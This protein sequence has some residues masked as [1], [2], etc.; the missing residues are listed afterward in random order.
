MSYPIQIGL[1]AR[2]AA[3]LALAWRQF[4]N[5]R[6]INRL[7]ELSDDQ[8]KDIGLTRSDVRRVRHAFP[9]PLQATALTGLAREKSMQ[10][11][12]Q[13]RSVKV[14]SLENPALS[15]AAASSMPLEGQLAA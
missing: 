13:S 9:T 4:Q 10:A 5:R 14:V 15:E 1:I 8:L 7:N 11:L 2:S 3:L 6:Q 12:L